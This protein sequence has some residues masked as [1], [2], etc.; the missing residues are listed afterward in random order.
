MLWGLAGGMAVVLALWVITVGQRA[1]Q[2][3]VTGTGQASVGGPFQLATLQ[4]KAFSNTDLEGR[5][6]LV[7]FGFTHCP[8]IC[9]TTLSE[10]TVFMNEL[11]A[12][13]EKVVPVF[14][15]VDPERDTADLLGQYMTAFDPRIVA[16]RGTPEQTERALKAFAAYARKTDTGN[17]DY[18]MEHTAG[19][20]LIDADGEFAGKLDLH[21]PK[22]TQLAKLRRL[23]ASAE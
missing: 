18:T 11:G 12:D 23:I 13:A 6:Y 4:G 14:I 21:E 5:P 8:D 10:L 22:A 3:P 9:P 2:T 17:G 19:V 20:V 16:L 15:T 7:F 1:L